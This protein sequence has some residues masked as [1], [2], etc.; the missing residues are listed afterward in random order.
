LIASLRID[1]WWI[2]SQ[3]HNLANLFVVVQ[4]LI[5][6]HQEAKKHI[7]G[8]NFGKISIEAFALMINARKGFFAINLQ[9]QIIHFFHKY[10][11]NF[12]QIF[13]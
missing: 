11:I 1:E 12:F 4:Q 6:Y 2:F 9:L 13:L 10:S 8:S 5:Q 7:L 3:N